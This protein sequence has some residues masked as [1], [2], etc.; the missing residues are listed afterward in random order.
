MRMKSLF[1]EAQRGEERRV[2]SKRN[3]FIEI[4]VDG[5]R[6]SPK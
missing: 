6:F 4:I 2:R 3:H 5:N 1:E